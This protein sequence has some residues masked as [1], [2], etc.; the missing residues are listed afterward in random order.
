MYTCASLTYST[1][2][3]AGFTDLPWD[4]ATNEKKEKRYKEMM[5]DRN[6]IVSDVQDLLQNTLEGIY[7][8]SSDIVLV[9]RLEGVPMKLRLAPEMGS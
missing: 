4:G 2:A 6:P 9:D 8:R 1:L 7:V 3:V 5:R